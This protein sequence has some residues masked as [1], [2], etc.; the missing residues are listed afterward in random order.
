MGRRQRT[1]LGVIPRLLSGFASGPAQ[2]KTSRVEHTAVE[3]S[4][5]WLGTRELGRIR[6]HS[7]SK[8]GF[9]ASQSVTVFVF[10]SPVSELSPPSP[11]PAL[12]AGHG[13]SPT[14]SQHGHGV[15][16][17]SNRHGWP[18][19]PSPA[20]ARARQRRRRVA[21]RPSVSAASATDLE[22]D[23]PATVPT[24]FESAR[25]PGLSLRLVTSQTVSVAPTQTKPKSR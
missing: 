3:D 11:G 12:S 22:H 17:H 19:G 1:H 16:S 15:P 6:R 5:D 23:M 10:T 4:E 25:S 21:V 18:A 9:R 24:Y 14:R 7:A 2:F 20:G 13:S 8:S